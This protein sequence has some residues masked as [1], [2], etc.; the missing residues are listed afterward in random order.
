MYASRCLTA[1][2]TA[3]VVLSFRQEVIPQQWIHIAVFPVLLGPLTAA[4]QGR[5]EDVRDK[6]CISWRKLSSRITSVDTKCWNYFGVSAVLNAAAFTFSLWHTV[7]FVSDV[8]TF[9]TAHFPTVC[10]SNSIVTIVA[11]LF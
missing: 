7:V 9:I 10:C 8:L 3:R 4:A 1:V 2:I 6:G 5:D 11:Q